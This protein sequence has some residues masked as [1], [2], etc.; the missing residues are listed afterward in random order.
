MQL[1]KSACELKPVCCKPY[2]DSSN[3]YFPA[4]RKRYSNLPGYVNPSSYRTD[5]VAVAVQHYGLRIE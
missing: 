4:Y 5:E 3:Y 2:I 1:L